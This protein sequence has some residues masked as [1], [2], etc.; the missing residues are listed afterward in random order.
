M[1][2]TY[3]N[4][5][6]NWFDLDFPLPG[7]KCRLY[8]HIICR[9]SWTD[10]TRFTCYR[11]VVYFLSSSMQCNVCKLY[12]FDGIRQQQGWLF[13]SSHSFFFW[14]NVV[15]LFFLFDLLEKFFL[16]FDYKIFFDC[17]EAY[18]FLNRLD[19]ADKFNLLWSN[20][21]DYC[22]KIWTVSSSPKNNFILLSDKRSAPRKSIAC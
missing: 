10:L 21:N 3:T 12:S 13:I 15:F 22:G 2:S 1:C 19:R 5:T 4:Y 11:R 17:N 20:I 7:V 6:S 9:I 14:W 18:Q 8:T 16:P